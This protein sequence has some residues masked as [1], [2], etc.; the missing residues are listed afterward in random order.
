M[1]PPGRVLAT[2]IDI[3]NDKPRPDDNFL[4]DTNVWLW[5]TYTRATI[6]PHAQRTA[7]YEHYLKDALSTKARLLRCGVSLAELAHVIEDFEWKLHCDTKGQARRKEY[8][9]LDAERTAVATLIEQ[10]WAQVSSM[11][12]LIETKMDARFVADCLLRVKSSVIDG[13]DAVLV[14]SAVTSGIAQIITDDSDY[15]S[16]KGLEL[17]TRNPAVLAAAR[18]AG[19]TLSR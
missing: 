14:E 4:I 10:S 9:W 1:I 19:Q 5:Q 7:D 3:R 12:E 16:V 13:Y 11:S 18:S 17:F 2:V 8:R 15:C 6:G